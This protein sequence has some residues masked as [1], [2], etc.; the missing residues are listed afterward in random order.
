VHGSDL[1]IV[2]QGQIFDELPDVC[3]FDGVQQFFLIQCCFIQNDI[4]SDGIG[5]DKA[6]LQ[7]MSSTNLSRDI[8]TPVV[9]KPILSAAS[10][11]P[12]RDTPARVMNA[13]SRR[14]CRL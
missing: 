6:V 5:K 9:R 14:V 2:F 10:L 12:I 11:M 13:R 8:R 7:N 3:R 4:M 1:C